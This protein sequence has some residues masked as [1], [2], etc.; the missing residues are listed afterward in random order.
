[1]LE[2]WPSHTGS[3]RQYVVKNAP[4]TKNRVLSMA[5]GYLKKSYFQLATA[6][7]VI[8]VL[9]NIKLDLVQSNIRKKVYIGGHPKPCQTY[10]T[11]SKNWPN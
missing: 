8:S 3:M 1:M 7:F 6:K 2:H 11:L 4:K 5:R 10:A 9:D